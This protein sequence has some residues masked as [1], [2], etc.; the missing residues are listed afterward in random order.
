MTSTAVYS[1]A[2]LEESANEFAGEFM[3]HVATAVGYGENRVARIAHV[4]VVLM[5]AMASPGGG[6]SP[7]WRALYKT[8]DELLATASD[9]R[10]TL[11]SRAYLR[12]FLDENQDLAGD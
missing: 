5:T 6:S 11:S 2:S 7:A 8:I 12:A 9:V 1:S 4:K 3:L 10:Y